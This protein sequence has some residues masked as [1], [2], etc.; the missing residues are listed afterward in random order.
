[1]ILVSMTKLSTKTKD[2]IALVKDGKPIVIMCRNRP[3]AVLMS[4]RD[5]KI[6]LEL[7][8]DNELGRSMRANSIL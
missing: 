4:P 8:E 6:D 7:L 5:A 2:V 3:V 1:M